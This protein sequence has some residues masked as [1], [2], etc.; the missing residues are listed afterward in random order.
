[1]RLYALTHI[2]TRTNRAARPRQRAEQR[3]LV[4]LIGVTKEE[5]LLP[6]PL[7]NFGSQVLQAA[8]SR[9]QLVI[10]VL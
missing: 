5:G 3:V 6:A 10:L 9:Q 1:M 8:V 4:R 2:Q 7:R